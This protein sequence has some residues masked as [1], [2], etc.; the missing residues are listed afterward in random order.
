VAALHPALWLI[1]LVALGGLVVL[2]PNPILILI[3]VFAAMEL[4]RRWQMRGHPA[5]QA[6]YRVLPWQR[7]AVAVAYFGL[8]ALLVLGMHET[9]V[10]RNF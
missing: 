4:W 5:A 10:P 7:A 3:L 8:A 1:G 6:Y 9:H 2:R